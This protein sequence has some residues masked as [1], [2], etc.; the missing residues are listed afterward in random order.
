[1][2]KKLKIG[3][4]S[5]SCCND[6]TIVFTEL[7]NNN[8]STWKR[9]IDFQYFPLLKKENKIGVL[10]VAFVEGAIA[11]EES[12]QELKKIRKSCKKLIAVGSCA[13][14]ALPAG[15]RNK[16]SKEKRKEIENL[17]RKFNLK[18]KVYSVSDIVKV[19]A[20]VPGCPMDEKIFLN[21]LNKQLK[22]FKIKK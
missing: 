15:Q 1:M 6:S 11:K 13:I 8:F 17:I 19:D 22:D 3:W 14:S 4:F 9:Q 12:K 2:N 5:F 7:L 10:D 18:R 21:V 20:E 16:F